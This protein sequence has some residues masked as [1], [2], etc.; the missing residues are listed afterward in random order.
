MGATAFAL[1]FLHSVK[2]SVAWYNGELPAGWREWLWIGLLPVW[3]FIY[4]RYYSVFR[5]G[6]RACSPENPST[7]RHDGP[8]GA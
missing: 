4:F 1:S 8:Q 3:V 2:I 5:P 6:C 7:A